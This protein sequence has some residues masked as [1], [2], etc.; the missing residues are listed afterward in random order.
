MLTNVGTG[1]AVDVNDPDPLNFGSK[2]TGIADGMHVWAFCLEGGE[3]SIT[4]FD[5]L[6]EG[7]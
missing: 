5:L 3:Y 4:A 6:G 1:E 7:W 2:G